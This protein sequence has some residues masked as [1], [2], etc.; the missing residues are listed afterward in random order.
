MNY[1][2]V[3]ELKTTYAPMLDYSG[4]SDTTISGMIGSASA[5]V[6]SYTNA[7]KGWGRE[8]ITDEEYASGTSVHTDADGNLVIPLIKRPLTSVNDVTDISI[9]LGAYRTHL[10]LQ[11]GGQ[12][13]LHS[14]APGWSIIYPNTW[15]VAT[16][17]LL[18]NQRLYNLRSFNYFIWLSY[19]AGY[20]TVPDDIKY[21]T[22][23]ATQ[24]IIAKRYN[25]A[26]ANR[27]SQGSMSTEYST[28]NKR[29]E[30]I[31]LA[32]AKSYLDK[33]VRVI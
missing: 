14:P 16:G 32:E 7:T 15:L 23:L 28:S 9:K 21:A 8:T 30:N 20:T 12:I 25:P 1:I 24:N 19:T 31:L 18:S 33:Y 13:V 6:D 10:T 5:W 17:T 2:T 26:G 3:D 22:A 4:L 29:Y 27:L 11:T